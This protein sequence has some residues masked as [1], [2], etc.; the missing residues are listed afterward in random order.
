MVSA[1]TRRLMA[2]GGGV[3][4]GGVLGPAVLAPDGSVKGMLAGLGVGLLV[5]AL[6]RG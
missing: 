4:A 3:L 2:C 1:G 6:V 5:A